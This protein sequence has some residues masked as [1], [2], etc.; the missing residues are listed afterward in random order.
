MAIIFESVRFS[1]RIDSQDE[2]IRRRKTTQDLYYLVHL[3]NTHNRDGLSGYYITAAS[4]GTL[5]NIQF[6]ISN[7]DLQKKEFRAMLNAEKSAADILLFDH[8]TQQLLF[9]IKPKWKDGQYQWIDASGVKIASESG[10]GGEYK[11][12]IDV[13]LQQEKRD[14]IVA[15]WILRLW[16]D[17][18]ESRVE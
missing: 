1:E 14:A 6:D 5:G 18:A 2:K 13:P 11:L 16:H 3:Q 4:P 15:L 17:I 10:E 9:D 8:D 12:H 7:A